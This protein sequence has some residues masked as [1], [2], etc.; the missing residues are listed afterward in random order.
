[1]CVTCASAVGFKSVSGA[2]VA[3]FILM[4]VIA[5]TVWSPRFVI[6]SAAAVFTLLHCIL[7]MPHAPAMFCLCNV[8][9]M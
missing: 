7:S 1:M 2:V 4:L 8:D 6:V 5:C 9:A 3:L